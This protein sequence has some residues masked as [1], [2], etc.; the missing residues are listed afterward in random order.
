MTIISR[1]PCPWRRVKKQEN[2]WKRVTT[3]LFRC[4]GADLHHDSTLQQWWTSVKRQFARCMNAQCYRSKQL[5]FSVS[6]LKVSHRG[7]I[8]SKKYW[9]KEANFMSFFQAMW[10]CDPGLVLLRTL[11][12]TKHQFTHWPLKMPQWRLALNTCKPRVFKAAG[13][14][15]P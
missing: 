5:A 12:S 1:C 2:Q 11:N 14:F 4:K 7:D 3:S 9:K 10:L 15:L 13:A 8:Y 6:H